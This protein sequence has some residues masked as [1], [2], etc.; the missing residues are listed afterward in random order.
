MKGYL[1]RKFTNKYFGGVY[2][3]VFICKDCVELMPEGS[4]KVFK[5]SLPR[6]V[7]EFEECLGQA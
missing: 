5:V 3:L 6:F 2:T 7:Q 4:Q 1:M